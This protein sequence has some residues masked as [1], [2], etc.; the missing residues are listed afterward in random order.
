MKHNYAATTDHFPT[1]DSTFLEAKIKWDEGPDKRTY[2][3]YSVS[4]LHIIPLEILLY[5]LLCFWEIESALE[6]LVCSLHFQ[7]EQH[8]LLQ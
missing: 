2:I 3:L 5:S 6:A 1:D 8:S 4:D 7:S